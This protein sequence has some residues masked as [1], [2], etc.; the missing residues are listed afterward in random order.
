[1]LHLYF[2]IEK[3]DLRRHL[4]NRRKGLQGVTFL[5]V[6]YNITFAG[7][8]FSVRFVQKKMPRSVSVALLKS[9]PS[10]CS[11]VSYIFFW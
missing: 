2:K 11:Q 6:M 8:N 7:H 9:E 4:G 1:M 10:A 3:Y 5:C